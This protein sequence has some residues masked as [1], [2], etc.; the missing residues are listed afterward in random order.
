MRYYVKYSKL[1]NATK[2][3]NKNLTKYNFKN[4]DLKMSI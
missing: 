3:D 4:L 1:K 2:N